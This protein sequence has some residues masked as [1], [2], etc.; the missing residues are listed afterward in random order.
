MLD[1]IGLTSI[2]QLIEKT[3]PAAIRLAKPLQ[4]G[5][6]MSEHQY[7]TKAMELG[8]KNI[9]AKSY[10]GMG[11][12][13]TFV[14]TVILRN[15]LE[16]PG[17]YTAYTPYQ[18]EIAQGRLEAL[19]NY[20]T[21]I[22]D[23]TGMEIANASLLDEGTAAGEAM[24]ML[25]AETKKANANKFFVS[26]LCFP[27]TIDVL[28]TRATPIGIELVIGNHEE[29][30]NDGSFFGALVQYPAANGEAIDYRAFTEKVKASDC[31]VAVASDLLALTL[32]TPPGEWGADVVVGSS[33]RFGVPM[34]YGGPH[35]AFLATKDAYKRS[36]PGRLVGVSVDSH[37]NRAFTTILS[38]MNNHLKI[39]KNTSL[40]IQ[41]IG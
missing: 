19:L 26:E 39:L 10:I 30:E 41:K 9:V 5:D 36:L 27:Q 24:H 21:M 15:V 35:A 1:T 3:V 23:L 33:Q 25:F 4:I 31:F 28:K 6:A 13:P 2:D 38:G 37:G 20:Q 18:A 34:G 11:Y 17:W 29:F 40:I 8:K 12:H 7:L 14:P 16:N 32:L 22:I